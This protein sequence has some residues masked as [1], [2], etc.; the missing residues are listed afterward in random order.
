MNTLTREAQERLDR[1]L[2]D[3]RSSL[4]SCRTIDP[5]EVEADVTEH[6]NGEL[7][8]LTEPVSLADLE[9][10]LERL[11]RPDQWLPAEELPWWRRA[12]RQLRTG[13]ADYRLAFISFGL[14]VSAFLF[15]R[16]SAPVLILASFC[17]SRAALAEASKRDGLG[18]QRWLF[19]PSLVVVY[20]LVLVGIFFGL[21]GGFF[22]MAISFLRDWAPLGVAERQA[23]MMAPFFSAAAAFL[24]LGALF[25]ISPAVPR[26]V[27]RPFANWFTRKW[28][29]V[30]ILLG[31]VF[32]AFF[33]VS[34]LVIFA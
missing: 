11:G 20:A 22:W 6:I 30:L 7:E 13:P 16:L 15:G 18:P 9:G 25:T 33:G 3:V 8:G 34:A 2:G 5:Q 24:S 12:V 4:R 1:Y 21:G 28:G 26:F 23:L 10:V 14:L 31:L 32:A 19:Y 17:V 27:F 29:V